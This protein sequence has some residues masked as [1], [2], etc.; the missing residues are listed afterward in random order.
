MMAALDELGISNAL[1]ERPLLI[2]GEEQQG[3]GSA[4]W[5]LKSALLKKLGTGKGAS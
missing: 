2:A 5:P 4:I 3:K 1:A